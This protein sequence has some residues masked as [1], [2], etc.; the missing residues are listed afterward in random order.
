MKNK[1]DLCCIFIEENNDPNGRFLELKNRLTTLLSGYSDR[2]MQDFPSPYDRSKIVITGM[3]T[4]YDDSKIRKKILESPLDNVIAIMQ[5]TEKFLDLKTS[6]ILDHYKDFYD[7]FNFKNILCV[8]TLATFSQDFINL[9]FSEYF[10]DNAED[11]IQKIELLKKTISLQ[12]EEKKKLVV[13]WCEQFFFLLDRNDFNLDEKNKIFD[14]LFSCINDFDERDW[15]PNEENE[16]KNILEDAISKGNK[17]KVAKCAVVYSIKRIYMRLDEKWINDNIDTIFKNDIEGY[18]YSYSMFA[19]SDFYTVQFVKKL[20]K[21]N[22]FNELMS[23]KEYQRNTGRFIFSFLY[24]FVLGNYEEKYLSS[25]LYLDDIKTHTSSFL[26]AVKE[27]FV[28]NNMTRFVRLLNIICESNN[29][30]SESLF[31]EILRKM[32]NYP[33]I[34]E[35]CFKKALV[36]GECGFDG[37]HVKRLSEVLSKDYFD[38]SEI[39]SIIQAISKNIDDFYYNKD[40]LESL[41]KKADWQGSENQKKLYDLIVLYRNK[42]PELA[43][44]MLESL[45]FSKVVG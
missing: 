28:Q 38:N 10:K 5:K 18:N 17:G 36:L 40:D 34:K 25:I 19:Y 43:S 27:D 20:I 42:D 3:P 16:S 26:V 41:F 29:K 14:F 1:V 11:N 15:L 33:E 21:H 12:K 32:G 24:D 22:I 45:K 37:M 31:I 8:E 39:V 13:K 44:K 2:D 35:N 4:T 23:S 7:K 9:F 6:I 30:K